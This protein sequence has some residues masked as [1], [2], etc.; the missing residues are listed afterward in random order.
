MRPLPSRTSILAFAVIAPLLLRLPLQLLSRWAQRSARGKE[1]FDER[2]M[3]S[4]VDAVLSG[5]PAWIRAWRCVPRGLTRFYFLRHAASDVTL[6]FGVDRSGA[7]AGHCWL[8]VDG[9]PL[10]EPRDPRPL[11]VQTFA[12]DNRPPRD[13]R[14]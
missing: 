8:T 6:A 1:T 2:V 4:H 9:V 5:A 13:H 10:D 3:L 7:P 12:L 11:Y 14:R